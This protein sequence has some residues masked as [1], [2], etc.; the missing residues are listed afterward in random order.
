MLNL[1]NSK[2]NN[3]TPNQGFDR[4]SGRQRDLAL[5]IQ[6]LE[7]NVDYIWCPKDDLGIDGLLT[8]L[9]HQ[10]VDL[11][12]FSLRSAF[13]VPWTEIALRL[14]QLVM[15]LCKACLISTFRFYK[16]LLT[17]K[18]HCPRIQGLYFNDST[19][20]IAIAQSNPAPA[21]GAADGQFIPTNIFPRIGTYYVTYGSKT[22]LL[23]TALD[24]V[25]SK[26]KDIEHLVS[27]LR[28]TSC[29]LEV[30]GL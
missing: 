1:M 9:Q 19:F 25:V 21:I 13:T 24:V 12:T 17:K 27:L 7:I 26:H 16:V 28:N 22:H 2:R 6:T 3:K 23:L 8:I 15:D 30:L 14:A 10:A 18:Q 29:S 4:Y 20:T 11:Q 5:F